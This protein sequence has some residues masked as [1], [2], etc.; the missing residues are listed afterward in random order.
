MA[1]TPERVLP[2]EQDTALKTHLI[3][4]AFLTVLTAALVMLPGGGVAGA[5]WSG[6]AA[7]NSNADTDCDGVVGVRDGQYLL[8]ALM[9]VPIAQSEPFTDAGDTD[10]V[11]PLP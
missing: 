3:V 5:A 9:G 11:I 1:P 6:P 7:L 2:P 4:L 10:T 8:T